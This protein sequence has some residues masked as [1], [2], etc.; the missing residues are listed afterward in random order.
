M[1][2]EYAAE[3]RMDYAIFMLLLLL[4]LVAS[5]RGHALELPLYL[6][7]VVWVLAHLIGEMTTPLALSF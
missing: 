2:R 3:A 4:A 5:W 1:L 6:I 7:T